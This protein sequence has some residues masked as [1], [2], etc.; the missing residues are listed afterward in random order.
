MKCR[1][2]TARRYQS[3]E[4]RVSVPTLSMEKSPPAMV[5]VLRGAVRS[6]FLRSISRCGTRYLAGTGR[7]EPPVLVRQVAVH[8][9]YT[10][11]GVQGRTTSQQG[12]KQHSRYGDGAAQRIQPRQDGGQNRYLLGR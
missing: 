4:L 6:P 8:G 3:D 1:V 9:R 10:G 2:S 7:R 12:T 5:G 11:R